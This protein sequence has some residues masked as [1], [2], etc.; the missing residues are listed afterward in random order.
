LHG[1][2]LLYPKETRSQIPEWTKFDIVF[3]QIRMLTSEYL[4]RLPINMLARCPYCQVEILQPFDNFS[5]LGLCQDFKVTKIYEGGREWHTDTPPRQRCKHALFATLFIN[6]NNHIPDDL[7]VW[8]QELGLPGQGSLPLNSSPHIIVWPLIAQH[9]SA[10]IHTL[11]IARLDDPEPVHRYSAYFITYFANDVSN[12]DK[13]WVSGGVELGYRIPATSN[14]QID[15]G[16]EKWIHAGR[17]FWINPKNKEQLIQKPV[18]SFPYGNIQPQGWYRIAK[19]IEVDGPYFYDNDFIWQGKAP[20]HNE[21]F[22]Q[23][24]E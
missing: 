19:N 10:V 21:S 14:I 13:M 18:A 16:L 1:Q 17:L 4:L 24:I 23:T 12:I 5:L 2:I 7:P 9:T 8:S 6:L 20:H 22:S 15:L 11:P 3:K